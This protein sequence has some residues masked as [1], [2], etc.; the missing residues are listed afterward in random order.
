MP[1]E[2]SKNSSEIQT[3]QSTKGIGPVNANQPIVKQDTETK[4]KPRYQ[5]IFFGF[6]S[7]HSGRWGLTIREPKNIDGE[8]LALKNNLTNMSSMN[9]APKA[10][11]GP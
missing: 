11:R 5:A 9:R 10:L 6:A 3:P 4:P 1:N 8:Y 2:D 7:T